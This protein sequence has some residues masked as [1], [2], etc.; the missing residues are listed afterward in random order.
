[1]TL[2]IETQNL[3]DRQLQLTVK[4]PPDRIEAA[5]HRAARHLSE[6]TRIAGFRPGKAPYELV[7]QKLGEEAV[8]EEALDHLGQE[9]Y[10]QALEDSSLEPIA[11]GSLDEVVSRDPL[12]LRYTVPLQPEIELGAYRDL[13]LGYEE[14]SVTDESLEQVL[15]ELRQQQALIEPADRPAQTG[16]VAVIDVH[17][18][19]KPDGDEKPEGV[20]LD[21][22]GVSVL[23]APTTDFPVPG[24]SDQ[25]VGLAS[26]EA[27]EVDHEF[28]EDYANEALRG[29]KATFAVQV[30][31]V[32]SRLVPEWSDDLARNLGEFT[33][34]LDLRVK[35]RQSLQEQANRR[36]EDAY[37]EQVV[38]QLVKTVQVRFPPV[39]L[40]DELDLMLRDLDRRLRGQ[41]LTLEDYLK[42]E[43]KTEPDLR[44]E[45]EPRA[46]ERLVKSLVLG[47]VVEAEGLSV[48]LEE[49][50][51]E[52]DRLS[53]PLKEQSENL[54]KVLDTP[55]SRHRIELDLLTEKAV[56][57]LADLARGRSTE[58]PR[59][60]PK[61]PEESHV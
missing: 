25:L 39:L 52:I 9:V 33:D 41:R 56:R 12:V 4:V 59:E 40:R 32:K 29:R 38:D 48:T 60:A 34:L 16:D 21:E 50:D 6:H 13:R 19:L 54:R 35:V 49:V 10:R 45:L 61:P 55:A 37:A 43:K 8:F 18:T 46:R 57:R 44:T 53:A 2:D 28:P 58:A 7:L 3:E 26:G 5:M 42:I 1:L 31:E 47:K 24:I 30:K 11:P 14:P 23:L 27:K 15:D 17:G 22:H 20:L 51:A 36:A